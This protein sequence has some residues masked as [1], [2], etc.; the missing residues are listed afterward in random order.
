MPSFVR[1]KLLWFYWDPE[2]NL[3][4]GVI[5]AGLVLYIVRICA[6]LMFPELFT[7]SV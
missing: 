4:L 3:D 5:C 7:G 6:C 2:R 1:E